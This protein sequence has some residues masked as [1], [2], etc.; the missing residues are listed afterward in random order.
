MSVFLF[1]IQFVKELTHCPRMMS[2]RREK[3]ISV[4]NVPK[5]GSL[6]LTMI[7]AASVSTVSGAVTADALNKDNSFDFLVFAQIWEAVFNTSATL[8]SPG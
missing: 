2:T 5:M 7:Y 1:I 3:Y 8:F 4:S 6:I